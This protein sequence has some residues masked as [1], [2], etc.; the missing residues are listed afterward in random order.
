MSA[1]SGHTP[2]ALLA[3]L[4]AGE[5]AAGAPA[6]VVSTGRSLKGRA[7][8]AISQSMG[9]GSGGGGYQISWT[10]IRMGM[11]PSQAPICPNGSDVASSRTRALIALE[12]IGLSHGISA[13]ATAGLEAETVSDTLH[14]L[15]TIASPQVTPCI[16]VV[17][18][19]TG[20]PRASSAQVCV[21]PSSSR[22]E[23]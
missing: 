15:T 8:S 22:D 4:F 7:A 23:L 3:Q 12:H 18:R 2:A 6:E 1:A 9:T 17:G 5:A 11:Q 20:E 10:R 13:A 16:L 14:V 19:A 21:A